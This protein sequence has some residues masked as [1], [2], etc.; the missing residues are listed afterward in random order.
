CVWNMDEIDTFVFP[1]SLRKRLGLPNMLVV[2]TLDAATG[3]LV[4]LNR[5]VPD[6]ARGPES[7]DLAA[8]G[9]FIV[10]ATPDGMLTSSCPPNTVC[11][12]T[13]FAAPVVAGAAAL[14]FARNYDILKGMPAVVR[15]KILFAVSP[16]PPLGVDA[17]PGFPTFS[18]LVLSE[19]MLNTL[20]AVQ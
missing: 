9:D 2:T 19:G 8:P 18:G 12:G 4:N 16:R 1:A 20:G 3:Q 11:A 15:F 13:S 14:V 6:R 7:I 17:A 10:V 5:T